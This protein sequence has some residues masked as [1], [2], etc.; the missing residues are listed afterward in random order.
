MK[1]EGLLNR[2]VIFKL[3]G[4]NPLDSTVLKQDETGYWIRGGT[5]APQLEQSNCSR[6]ESDVRYLEFTRI[7]WLRAAR[8]RS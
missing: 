3:H 4:M 8:Q 2:L 7:E 6:P 5:L 1:R